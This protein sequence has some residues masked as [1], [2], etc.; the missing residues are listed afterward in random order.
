MK[1]NRK[2]SLW[3]V[4]TTMLTLAACMMA[5][6]S[7]DSSVVYDES[8][9][10]DSKGWNAA[11]TLMFN[12]E[13]TDTSNTYLCFLDI[14]N[15][16]SYPY[17][18]LYLSIKTIYPDGAVAIDTNIEFILAEKDGRWRGRKDGEYIDG[19][20]PLCYFHFPEKGLYQFQ[21]SHAMR[22]SVLGGIKDI[23]MIV[24]K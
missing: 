4:G 2:K 14:R 21:V 18:N 10:I 19:R 23:T 24:K 15:T 7:C 3:A 11:N 17:S 1:D 12:Y 9:H 5:M 20:Y 6:A 22:D 16:D 13:A 8:H